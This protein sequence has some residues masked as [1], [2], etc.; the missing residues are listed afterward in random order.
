MK[1][2]DI[3]REIKQLSSK[4]IIIKLPEETDDQFEDELN[5]KIFKPLNIPS[6]TCHFDDDLNMRFCL[7]EE[8]A[9]NFEKYLNE[10][11]VKYKK[12]DLRFSNEDECI[13]DFYVNTSYIE[14]LR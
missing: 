6:M 14:I 10:H 7:T 5:I 2:V 4:P 8:G 3:I 12:D 1:L 11:N 13:Y 9:Y